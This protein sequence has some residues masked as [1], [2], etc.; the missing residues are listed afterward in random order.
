MS[1]TRVSLSG[2]NKI[3]VY[4]L[5]Q[6]VNFATCGQHV[7][8]SVKHSSAI[9]VHPGKERL[10]FLIF[11]HDIACINLRFIQIK[12]NGIVLFVSRKG[13]TFAM[14]NPGSP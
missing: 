14:L 13:V 10:D 4:D 11:R 3:Y 8:Q 5:F 12:T 2:R 7:I 1:R 6:C 9:D